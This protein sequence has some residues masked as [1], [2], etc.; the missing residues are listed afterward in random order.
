LPYHYPVELLAKICA[1]VDSLYCLRS[2][3]R[4]SKPY[5]GET[6][7]SE[8]DIRCAP[9]FAS[10][11]LYPW[12]GVGVAPRQTAQLQRRRRL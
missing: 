4:T 6:V 1:I 12:F 10:V 3:S 5:F 7:G 11:T 9:E 2:F 8:E